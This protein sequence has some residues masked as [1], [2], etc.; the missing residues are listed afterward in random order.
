MVERTWR[1]RISGGGRVH[2]A[3]ILL[4]GRHVLTC[5]HVVE[6]AL[7]TADP[8]SGAV[9]VSLPLWPA[10]GR[11]PARLV[12][13]GWHPADD[14]GRGDIAVLEVEGE[15]FAGLAAAPL[16]RVAEPRGRAVHVFGHP[17]HH[18][19]GI[20]A[21]AWI[22]GLAGGG[23]W[24][25]LE[26][27]SVTGRAIEEGFSG[28]GVVDSLTGT[29]VGLV[30]A[31]DRDVQA[32]VAWMIPLDVAASRWEPL[33][34]L[35]PA[36]PWP[37]GAG[38][39]AGSRA[40]ADADPIALG[41]H[42][43]ISLSP[44]EPPLPAYVVREHDLA[45]RRE[46]D[47]ALLGSRMVVLAG[48]SSSG[49]TRS[50]YEAVRE[51]LSD[52][53]LVHPFTAT[54]LVTL[55][56]RPD[57]LPRT[58]VWL[59]E[60]QVY[61]D[62]AD[63]EKAAAALRRTLARG[64]PTLIVTTLW[65]EF[66][67]RFTRQPR[68]G[69]A[70]PHRQVRE[71]LDGVVK[72]NVP[73]RF[74]DAGIRAAERLAVAD[75]R[76]A[77]ALDARHHGHGITQILA[78]GP[79]LI[80]RWENAPAPYGR[81][82][83]TAAI[84]ARRLG[85]SAPLDPGLLR[86]A[87]VLHLTGPELAG[88]AATWF[89]EATEYACEQVKGAIAPLTG[90]STTIGR[91]DGYLVADYLYQHGRAARRVVPVPDAF[92]ELLLRYT[93][94]PD[95]LNRL[96][97]AAV[98][99]GRFR[100]ACDLWR[101]ALARGDTAMTWALRRLLLRAGRAG[102]AADVL[103]DAAAA[104]DA[105]ASRLVI[106]LSRR[107]GDAAGIERALRQ[108]AASGHTGAPRELA[109]LLHRVGRAEEAERLLRSVGGQAAEH[110]LAALR[111]RT[112]K[113]G[114][115]E[116]T[117]TRVPEN[118]EDGSISTTTLLSRRAEQDAH[119]PPDG[120]VSA[121]PSGAVEG[122]RPAPDVPAGTEPPASPEA[123]GQG[124][125]RPPRLTL[126]LREG[127]LASTEAVDELQRRGHTTPPEHAPRATANT[128][129]PERVIRAGAGAGPPEHVLRAAVTAGEAGASSKLALFLHAAGRRDESLLVLRRAAVSGE[130]GAIPLLEVLLERAN[131]E[132]E[133][134]DLA[135]HGLT[136][137]GSTAPRW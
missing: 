88:A 64:G 13:G 62:G 89:D 7:G 97:S 135:R 86:E 24:L 127:V 18:D 137:D 75:P 38:N 80:D 122:T 60:G 110:L 102:E 117:T 65:P 22:S 95:D 44:G 82:L 123:G 69:A 107:S 74:D 61:L 68:L 53:R 134:A 133:A 54:E 56:D 51:R 26:A 19:D 42:R 108:A 31:R 118:G 6:R 57:P 91:V 72:I 106:A 55:L 8:R 100:H 17:R 99:R 67:Q 39:T 16:G 59:N 37:A 70:D 98:A 113:A 85:A 46:A 36:A 4:D 66:W 87:C 23:E 132:H 25:Q 94:E 101:A 128:R 5:A 129:R 41:V 126:K 96:G 48:G 120:A 93:T 15:A 103:R 119:P 78:G 32:R 11:H 9:T 71:L 83:I 47:L 35:L 52:W 90:T 73:E 131:R 1:V 43:A 121:E 58:V 84:D 81:A 104:G 30:V 3:G 33:R 136:A 92:W 112:A 76:L 125:V 29:V 10:A 2:G 114:D 49:K 116:H 111:G 63:G 40:V 20:E 105:E 79:D 77:R 109:V 115:P 34:G 45:L 27:R 21:Q 124:T 28:G 12:E 130:P 50:A 14:E